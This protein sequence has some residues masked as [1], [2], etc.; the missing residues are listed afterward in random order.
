MFRVGQNTDIYE[1]IN[2]RD[3]T[4]VCKLT[5]KEHWN[6]I[7]T[8]TF[9]KLLT[10]TTAIHRCLWW[11][12]QERYQFSQSLIWTKQIHIQMLKGALNLVMTTSSIL[13]GIPEFHFLFHG[14]VCFS[15]ANFSVV[16]QEIKIN[17]IYFPLVVLT[18]LV[19]LGIVLFPL[20]NI[21]ITITLICVI[22]SWTIKT[23]VLFFT[24]YLKLSHSWLIATIM[25][26]E[27]WIFALD[28]FERT[29]FHCPASSWCS[30]KITIILPSFILQSSDLQ[31]VHFTSQHYWLDQ[32]S[33]PRPIQKKNHA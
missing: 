15:S 4:R 3:I 12:T 14:W 29:C 32:F 18:L 25:L 13:D 31:F 22:P 21:S 1:V 5:I 26:L 10:N 16:S 27:A 19:K 20:K 33:F 30:E 11:A 28:M 9:C 2:D 7:T 24:M 23:F 8:T 6:G 17:K